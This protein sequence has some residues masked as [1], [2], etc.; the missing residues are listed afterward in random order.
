MRG[1]VLGE[2]PL[3]LISFPVAGECLRRI[4]MGREAAIFPSMKCVSYGP[5]LLCRIASHFQHDGS[6]VL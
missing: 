1:L 6:F 2:I 4:C 5:V 3:G